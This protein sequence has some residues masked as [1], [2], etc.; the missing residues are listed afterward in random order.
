[1]MLVSLIL[2]TGRVCQNGVRLLLGNC[3]ERRAHQREASWRQLA[4]QDAAD[5]HERTHAS[6][7]DR[8]RHA[9]AAGE[10]VDEAAETAESDFHADVGD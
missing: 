5:A 10:Q 4:R 2:M 9:D 6:P 3:C 8:R 7:I 1:M